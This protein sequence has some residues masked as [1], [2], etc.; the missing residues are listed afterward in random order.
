MT[1]P[2][3]LSCQFGAAYGGVQHSLLDLVKH[4]DRQRFKPIV[5]CAPEGGVSQLAAREQAQVHTVGAGQF[6]RYSHKRPLGTC[7]DL[8]TVAREIVRLARTEGVRVVHAFDGMVFFAAALAQQQLKDLRVIWLDC[9]FNL[10]RYHFRLVMRWCFPRAARVAA[11][12]QVRLQ[13]LLAEGLDP[14]KAAV[15]PLGTDFHLQTLAPSSQMAQKGQEALRIGIVGRFVPIKN[16]ELFLQAAQLV[17]KRHPRVQFV[18]VGSQGLFP[19]EV[20]YYQS[21]LR[22]VDELGLREQ[23]LFHEPVEN[24]ATLLNTFDVLACSSHLETFGRTLIEA[25]AL[26]KPVVATAVGAIPEVVKDGETG[27]LVAPGDVAGFAA[28]LNQLIENAELRAQLGRCG[29][30]RVLQH[31]DVRTVARRWEQLYAELLAA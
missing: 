9:G 25:M 6:W 24:L 3:L 31:F 20:A 18:I 13:Q 12:S 7:I 22:L 26:G 29:H 8:A 21:L 2:V 10:Y 17:A 23:V 30:Q 14:A 11:I 28:R 15:M 1:T 5:L 19:A 27:F 4:L 16:F